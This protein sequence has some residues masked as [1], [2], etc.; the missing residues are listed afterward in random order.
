MK[1][2]LA[3]AAVLSLAISGG[4]FAQQTGESVREPVVVELFTSQG[5]SS[6]PPADALLKQLAQRSDIVALALHVDYW[7]YIGWKDIFASP[8]YSNR[9]KGYAQLGGRKMIYTPQMIVMGRQ[10]ISGIDGMGIADAIAGYQGEPRPVAL[11][12]RREGRELTLSLAPRVDLPDGPIT[13]QIARYIPLQSVEITRG[14]LAGHRIDYANIVNDLQQVA[15][16]DGQD[17]TEITVA[18]EGAQPAAV[19]VQQG[20]FGPVLAAAHVN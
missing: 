13:I 20:P 12:V 2:I 8:A 18:F 9:Q 14:E 16:W 19:L 7:D 6:C 5:C 15:L 4:A 1:S 11:D 17:A 3:L 10:D